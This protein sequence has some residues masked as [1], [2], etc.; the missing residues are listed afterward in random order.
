QTVRR[1]GDLM[2]VNLTRE[3]AGPGQEAGVVKTWRVE[4]G[5]DLRLIL[6]L[7][8]LPLGA[9]HEPVRRHGDPHGAREGPEMSIDLFAVEPHRDDP[10]ALVRGNEHRGPEL[11]QHARQAGSVITTESLGTGL[12]RR[13]GLRFVQLRLRFELHDTS[14]GLACRMPAHAGPVQCRGSP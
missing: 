5:A 10:S 12:C 8:Y 2:D 6:V 1:E 7:P 3:V 4:P 14:P 9:E 11:A 13:R